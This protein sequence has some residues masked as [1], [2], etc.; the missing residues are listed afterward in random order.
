VV[1]GL[2]LVANWL[3]VRNWL[4]Y[5]VLGLIVW[6]AFLQSGIHATLAALLM[7]FAIPDRSRL[8]EAELVHRL[9]DR[10][11]DLDRATQAGDRTAHA[12]AAER[13]D[14]L[15][16]AAGSP[17]RRLEHALHPLV[18]LVVLPLFALANAGV[19]PSGS[20]G[21]ALSDPVT[22]GV[23]AGL[24]L[25]KPVGV[26]L[27]AFAA[28]KLGIADLPDQVGWRQVL[29]VACLAG[30][31]FTMALFIAGLAFTEAASLEA[32]KLGI[33]AASTLSGILG[34]TYLRLGSTGAAAAAAGAGSR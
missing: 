25:G 13:V 9:R 33:L 31:G 32:A 22:M 27:F 6:L 10:L 2:A 24:L 20:V 23:V 17:L 5:L 7:A 19:R 26:F 12:L 16:E 30:I 21:A 3:Q 28:V 8:T 18:T 15:L 1:F 14:S 34:W 4:V 11:A 29:G